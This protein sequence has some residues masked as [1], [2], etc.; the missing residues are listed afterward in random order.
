MVFLLHETSCVSWDSLPLR[1]FHRSFCREVAFVQYESAYVSL[2]Y[3]QYKTFLTLVA[4]EWFFPCMREFVCFQTRYLSKIPVAL[5]AG[6]WL[7]SCMGKC[8]HFKSELFWE[9]LVTLSASKLLFSFMRV[10]VCLDITWLKEN[11]VTLV[12]GKRLLSCVGELVCFQVTC[13]LS[14]INVAGNN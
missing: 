8:V 11:V 12:G 3:L 5:D 10:L 1:K 4:G 14:I 13:V 6:K 2:S 9:R 7:L